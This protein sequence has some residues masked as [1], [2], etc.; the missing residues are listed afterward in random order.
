MSLLVLCR[1]AKNQEASIL[2]MR[3]GLGVFVWRKIF[4]SLIGLYLAIF[5]SLLFTIL[6]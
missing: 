1:S 4:I 2:E 5:F 6:L 3:E